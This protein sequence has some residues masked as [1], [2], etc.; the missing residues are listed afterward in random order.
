VADALAAMGASQ[1]LIDPSAPEGHG[2]QVP[3]G[4]PPHTRAL[5]GPHRS[6]VGME[7]FLGTLG[8]T[9]EQLRPSMLLVAGDAD[10]ALAGALAA[11]KLGVPVGRVG[12]GLRCND[13]GL[14]EE[15]IR[16]ALD[17]TADDLFTDGP[18]ATLTLA[19]QGIPDERIVEVG[20]TLADSVNRWRSRAAVRAT[21]AGF[22][23][24]PRDYVLVALQRAENLADDARTDKLTRGLLALAER[25]RVLLML[26][27]HLTAA[28]ADRLD[29]LRA[30]G[31]ATSDPVDHVDFL[32]LQ[33]GAGAVLT[34]SAG[35][36]EEASMLNVPCYTLRHAT[37]RT[38]TLTLGTNVLLGDDPDELAHI[39]L[40]A[41]RDSQS[42][43]PRWDGQAGQRIA[44]HLLRT[45]AA[46]REGA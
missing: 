5:V 19:S 22:G 27:P 30:A 17:A 44:G 31:I 40:G 16:V 9:L 1:A 25:H 10:A 41:R 39:E 33:L 34:D 38:L 32:S 6:A 36:Q 45:V 21:W 12:A 37:E 15:I 18:E 7:Q 23:L 13:W 28:L 35:T 46:R 3:T 24:L 43:I 14:N 42:P 11:S 8:D 29:E 26:H 2:L 20:S 4:G